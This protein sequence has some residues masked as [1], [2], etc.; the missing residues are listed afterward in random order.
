MLRIVALLLSGSV[1]AWASDAA[2]DFRDGWVRSAP[3]TAKVLAA[4]G[5]LHNPSDHAV[6][7][8]SARCADFERATLHEMSMEQGVMKM[9]ELQRVEVAPH[10]DVALEP[11]A[12][13][14][15]LYGPKRPLKAGDRVALELSLQDGGSISAT[16]EVR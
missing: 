3:P 11:G 13:H 7:V 1:V 16:L 9:R 14:L 8:T 5:T 10:S 12:R 6:V 4:Y 2:A 15:M